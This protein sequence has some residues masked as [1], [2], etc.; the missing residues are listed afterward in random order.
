MT[1]SYSLHCR[2]TI[3][4]ILSHAGY[5]FPLHLIWLLDL[6]N[7]GCELCC[8][9]IYFPSFNKHNPVSVCHPAPCNWSQRC[10]T[11]DKTIVDIKWNKTNALHE[12]IF[13]YIIRHAMHCLNAKNYNFRRHREKQTNLFMSLRTEK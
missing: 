12:N 1:C 3:K 10:K 6:L 4:H 9:H 5:L 7:R 11:V 8:T 2:L 13:L